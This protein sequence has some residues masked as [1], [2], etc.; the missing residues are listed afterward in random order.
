MDT[1]RLEVGDLPA[2]DLRL[3]SP[4]LSTLMSSG[5]S[6]ANAAGARNKRDAM[7]KNFIM[8]IF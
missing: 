8:D 7:A 4:A 3:H 2:F 5:L 1:K 6:R